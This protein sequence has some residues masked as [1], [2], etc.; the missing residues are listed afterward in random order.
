[1]EFKFVIYYEKFWQNSWEGGGQ[2]AKH[3]TEDKPDFYYWA[4]I[5]YL[6]QHCPHSQLQLSNLF[7]KSQAILGG[8][9]LTSLTEVCGWYPLPLPL[10]PPSL[11]FPLLLLSWF[12]TCCLPFLIPQ[13][14]NSTVIVFGKKKKNS[15][16]YLTL[17]II[18]RLPWYSLRHH[19]F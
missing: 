11:H 10:S 16:L 3:R 1:M 12:Y 13:F 14:V 18:F 9:C 2:E 4:D 7:H 17:H 8:C 19:N 5:T 15:I 6:S